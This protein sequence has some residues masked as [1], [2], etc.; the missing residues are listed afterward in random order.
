[1]TEKK[2]NHFSLYKSD[3][4]EIGGEAARQA[5]QQDSTASKYNQI[6]FFGAPAKSDQNAD[7]QNLSNM[8]RIEFTIYDEN[9]MKGYTANMT[10]DRTTNPDI[11][12]MVATYLTIMGKDPK[13]YN[14][15]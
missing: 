7:D 1:M 9:N 8:M 15:A 4:K 12:T 2:N 6:N 10:V 14:L 5:A 3:T 11:E 13:D